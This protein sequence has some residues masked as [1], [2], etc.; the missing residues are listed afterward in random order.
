MID[1]LERADP[2]RKIAA[3]TSRLR[4]MVDERIGISAP[5]RPL[6][7][8]S[9]RPWLIAAAAF[10][11]VLAAGIPTLLR[12][13]SPSVF[14]PELEGIDDLPGVQA[15]V[16]LASGGLQAAAVD[17]DTIW[18]VTTL[19]NLL[20]RVSAESGDITAT[21]PIPARVEG[22]VVGDGRVWLMSGD[23]GGQVLR[24]DPEIGAVDLTLP[25][26][27]LPGWAHWFGDSLWVSNDQ[28]ELLQISAT[29]EIVSTRPGELKGGEGLG[30]L[31]VNDPE[32]NLIS[33]LDEDGTLGEI[34][35]PT[36]EGLDTM[37]G[38]GIRQVSE[39]DG[40]LWLMDG[41]YPWG[42]NLSTFDP[43]T[44]E[45]ASFGGITFGLLDLTTFDGSLWL[46]SHTD[47]LLIEVDPE[48]GQVRRYPMPGKVAG[49]LVADGSLWVTLY[50]PGAVLRIDPGAGL[51]QAADI[52]ADDWNRFPHRLLC[53]GSDTAGGPTI[54]LEPYD[55]LDYGSWSVIQ[56]QLS[57]D[58]YLVCANGYVQGESTPEQ[59]AADLDEALIE[60]GVPGPYLLVATGDGVHS[61]RLFADGREDIAG[62]VLV[63]PMPVGYG[64]FLD[65]LLP[66]T[67]GKPPE[68]DLDPTVSASLEDLGG[69]PLVVIGQDPTAVFLSRQ[70]IEGTGAEIAEA[71]N[72][73]WQDGLEF[74]AGLSTE[75]DSTV[76][77]G[78]GLHMVIWDRPELVVKEVTNLAQSVSD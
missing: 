37:S 43:V 30:F 44:G 27:G 42:T 75:S 3:D 33:S 5:L 17:G 32:T 78:T 76:A 13:D 59:R 58:G 64:D 15:V 16:P 48:S 21:Y 2:A 4:A 25:I 35:I 10:V 71:A 45:L 40:K 70:F 61:T 20:Q 66:G 26:G 57:S 41:D 38:A 74:Y 36:R 34:E 8:R 60:T 6:T 9:R 53:T 77:T 72:G 7:S 19:Q 12:Q 56:A 55:W 65:S 54:L 49:L 11:A 39:A 63:D 50:H 69:K 22:V 24:F 68:Q 18:V 31:W 62:V 23:D 73:Y 28:G 51:I 46:T 14:A 67:E 29:G 1:L 52:V 47:H